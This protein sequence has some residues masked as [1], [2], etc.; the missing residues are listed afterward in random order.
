[1]LGKIQ[2]FKAFINTS[3]PKMDGHSDLK[4][5]RIWHLNGHFQLQEPQISKRSNRTRKRTHERIT[6]V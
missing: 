1:M 3:C 4:F 6:E 2:K 5:K